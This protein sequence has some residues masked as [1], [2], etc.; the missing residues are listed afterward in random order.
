MLDTGARMTG[1]Q[2]AA[3]LLV[4]LGEDRAGEV[5]KHL[6][7]GEVEALSLEIAKGRR[8][9]APVVK[10][11][12]EEAASTVLA[13]GYV[14]EG[15]VEFARA[16]LERSVGPRKAEEIVTRLAA[17]IEHRPFE[18]LRRTPAEEIS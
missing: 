18:F 3:V 4:A 9:G 8:V 2:K 11:V 15:G 6:S 17:T 12:V 1:P 16:L 5:F 7:D 10:E 14:A 13:E